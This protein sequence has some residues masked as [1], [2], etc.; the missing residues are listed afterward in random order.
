MRVWTR[1]CRGKSRSYDA[2]RQGGAPRAS[3]GVHSCLIGLNPKPWHVI[4]HVSLSGPRSGWRQ[5]QG[6]GK[7]EQRSRWPNQATRPPIDTEPSAQFFFPEAEGAST[8]AGG[9]FGYR[10]VA[11][12]VVVTCRAHWHLDQAPGVRLPPLYTAARSELSSH[13]LLKTYSKCA[14]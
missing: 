8:A 5:W 12:Y 7:Q 14:C 13:K 10:E 3:Q 6:D 2:G 4:R 9:N 11:L 1:R